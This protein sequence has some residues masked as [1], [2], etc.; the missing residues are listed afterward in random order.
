MYIIYLTTKFYLYI[1]KLAFE[2]SDLRPPDVFIG[3]AIAEAL[4]FLGTP[5]AQVNVLFF[6]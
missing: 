5:L 3:C 2:R 4:L 1:F 6:K